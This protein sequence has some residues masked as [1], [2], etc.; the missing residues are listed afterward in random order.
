MVQ[1]RVKRKTADYSGLGKETLHALTDVFAGNSS[2]TTRDLRKA[3]L[4]VMAAGLFLAYLKISLNK[5]KDINAG[6]DVENTGDFD[7]NGPG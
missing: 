5:N 3:A 2:Y 7:P 6:P 1:V 4:A